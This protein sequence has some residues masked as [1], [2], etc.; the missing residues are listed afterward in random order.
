MREVAED[1]MN[2][3]AS[4]TKPSFTGKG[5]KNC[6]LC[7]SRMPNGYEGHLNECNDYREAIGNTWCP[8]C[9]INLPSANKTRTHLRFIHFMS[10]HNI[11]IRG[12]GDEMASKS[13]LAYTA[14]TSHSKQTRD[15][16]TEYPRHTEQRSNKLKL[17]T[18]EGEPDNDKENTEHR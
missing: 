10:D 18:P 6:R 7:E 1:L 2:A 15:Q 13:G 4:G 8:I 16:L 12:N 11:E 14:T 5:R 9:N 17:N 3:M